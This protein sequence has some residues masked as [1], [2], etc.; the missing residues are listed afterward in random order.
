M[1]THAERWWERVP[2][3]LGGWGFAVLVFL[4]FPFPEAEL[5]D[6]T[7][8]R[9]DPGVVSWGIYVGLIGFSIAIAHSTVFGIVVG[10]LGRA[11]AFWKWKRG[12]EVEQRGKTPPPGTS[13]NL[14]AVDRRKKRK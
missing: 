10:H 7:A 13:V 6:G 3:I 2:R 12:G 8:V 9:V 4:R 1:S 11:W 5:I 14:P